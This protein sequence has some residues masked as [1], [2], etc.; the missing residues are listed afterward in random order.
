MRGIHGTEVNTSLNGVGA[1]GL[2]AVEAFV[3]E[4]GDFEGTTEVFEKDLHL[5]SK[6]PFPALRMLF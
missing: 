6:P 2:W 1:Q 3:A 5:L 4:G